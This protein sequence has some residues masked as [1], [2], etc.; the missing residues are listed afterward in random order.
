MLVDCASPEAE[1]VEFCAVVVGWAS[2]EA[3]VA[4]DLG[5]SEA[6]SKFGPVVVGW[7][8]EAGAA[9]EDGVVDIGSNAVASPPLSSSVMLLSSRAT[10]TA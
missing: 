2:P 7:Y 10:R 6:G 5:S 3:G 4:V 8:A 9:L 1:D